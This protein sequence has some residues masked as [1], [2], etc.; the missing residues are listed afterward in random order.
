MMKPLSLKLFI[1]LERIL[2]T[3]S[4]GHGFAQIYTD[5]LTKED[6]EEKELFNEKGTFSLNTA[7]SFFET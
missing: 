5:W 1:N 4:I 2:S 3:T 6:H 7:P